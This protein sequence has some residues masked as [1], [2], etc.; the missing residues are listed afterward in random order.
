MS[1]KLKEKIKGKL[2]E[3]KGFD[4]IKDT[5]LK[6]I[7]GIL[8]SIA[9]SF[10][11]TVEITCKLAGM[12]TVANFEYQK[13]ELPSDE[14]E[15]EAEEDT[16]KLRVILEKI[17]GKVKD[18]IIQALTSKN[19]NT[20]EFTGGTESIPGLSVITDLNFRVIITLQ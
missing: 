4:E 5:L 7:K 17:V 18:R 6:V 10:Y 13:D 12:G 3:R 1:K 9:R 15:E 8:D 14:G 20:F 11:V 2:G 16:K 19:L